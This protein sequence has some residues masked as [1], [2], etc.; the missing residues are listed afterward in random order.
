MAFMA[1]LK[2]YL[3]MVSYEE[4]TKSLQE[5][6]EKDMPI[7]VPGS[8]LTYFKTV[9]RETG[10]DSIYAKLVQQ[11]EKKDTVVPQVYIYLLFIKANLLLL[12]FRPSKTIRQDIRNEVVKNRGSAYTSNVMILALREYYY[13]TGRYFPF[14]VIPE[15]YYI[16]LRKDMIRINLWVFLRLQS[17]NF[18]MLFQKY[19][20]YLSYVDKVMIWLKDGGIIE[21]IYNQVLPDR[22]K[23]EH[24]QFEEEKIII[25]HILLPILFLSV[26]S[27]LALISFLVEVLRCC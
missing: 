18:V 9:M 12:N 24:W 4:R 8:T 26:G 14:L 7:Y 16:K 20:P 25:Q 6:V 19:D 5:M 3:V 17:R 15:R 27:C 21:K 11:I 2:S 13:A 23:K 22:D 10:Q 1:K